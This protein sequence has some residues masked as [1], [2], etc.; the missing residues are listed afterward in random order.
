MYEINYL[1]LGF[2]IESNSNSSLMFNYSSKYLTETT[3]VY[4]KSMP[5]QIK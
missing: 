5:N 4:K 1:D 2:D 3:Y